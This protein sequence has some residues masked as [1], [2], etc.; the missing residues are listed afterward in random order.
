MNLTVPYHP[1][2][3]NNGSMG[4]NRGYQHILSAGIY[5]EIGPLS[6]QLKPEYLF[7]RIKILKG[8]EKGLMVIIQLYG[9]KDT[10]CGI[11]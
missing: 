4:P 2:N 9:Q 11:R 10:N 5:A 1:Y 8:L 3:R 6:I 7:Q